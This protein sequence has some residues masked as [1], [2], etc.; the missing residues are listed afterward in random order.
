[1]KRM[2]KVIER[3]IFG[4]VGSSS[5]DDDTFVA[6]FFFS[7]MKFSFVLFAFDIVVIFF[8]FFVKASR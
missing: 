3:K 4:D 5:L 8:F 1:M 7:T 6:L 2:P